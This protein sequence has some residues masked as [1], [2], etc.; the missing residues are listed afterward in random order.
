MK[1]LT[2]GIAT[3]IIG[4]IEIDVELTDNDYTVGELRKYLIS[5]YPRLAELRSLAIAVNE[6]YAENDCRLND[7]D[8]VALIPPVSGG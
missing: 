4:L 5:G 7:K 2:F 3:D 8:V 1:V 6:Q